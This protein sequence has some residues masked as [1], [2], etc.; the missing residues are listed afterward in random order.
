M[1][2]T[3]R[4]S[5]SLMEVMV[6]LILVSIV[7]GVSAYS[8]VPFYKT[9]RFRSEVNALY[10]LAQELQLEALSL[11]SDMKIRFT[12]KAGVWT[13]C[14]L[15]DEHVLKSQTLTLSHV[16]KVDINTGLIITFYSNGLIEPKK[17]I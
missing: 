16:D 2:K 6:V 13:A 5:L 3:P 9:Y 12:S 1:R 7:G 15:S 17:Q 8:L 10:D 11:Q 4:R 14:S